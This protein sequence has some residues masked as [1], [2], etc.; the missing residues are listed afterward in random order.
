[1]SIR[2]RRVICLLALF[3]CAAAAPA[4][5]AEFTLLA[6]P[7]EAS[8]D[9]PMLLKGII[10]DGD[11]AKLIALK[12]EQN[13]LLVLDSPGGSFAE[14]IK[15]A[16]YLHENQISTEIGA[17]QKCLSACA[18]AF[19]GGG[20]AGAE[21]LTFISRSL[22]PT[23]R[24]ALHAP[25]L[26][27]ADEKYQKDV[28]EV[29][30]ELAMRNIADLLRL[31]SSLS[32]DADLLPVI[33]EKGRREFY[34]VNSVDRAGQFKVR[35]AHDT[36]LAQFSPHMLFNY[37]RNGLAWWAKRSQVDYFTTI[38]ESSDNPLNNDVSYR[39]VLAGKEPNI[40]YRVQQIPAKTPGGYATTRVVLE[41]GHTEPE[42]IHTSQIC[43]I[44]IEKFSNDH[45]DVYCT[46]VYDLD[47]KDALAKAL[48]MREDN[49]KNLENG[50]PDSLCY[51]P[52]GE[53]TYL[54]AD[55][56]ITQVPKLLDL[57]KQRMASGRGADAP[58]NK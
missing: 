27:M 9:R 46:G 25:Y 11:L 29:A 40:A 19:L 35:I 41:I 28:V 7:K 55:T 12:G 18:I 49:D 53:Y 48:R 56:P 14:A 4:K 24:L 39:D 54:P 6:P 16:R 23:G 52:D 34:D 21:G 38:R 5:A 47:P 44:T 20:K 51:P 31:S 37:C 15:I 43:A 36:K 57:Y 22:H 33:L 2:I 30:Y 13:I 3:V 26:E 50:K 8:D 42:G 10:E 32:V 45:V 58:A 17:D 1:M